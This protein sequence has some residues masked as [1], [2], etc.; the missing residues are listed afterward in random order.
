MVFFVFCQKMVSSRLKMG[1]LILLCSTDNTLLDN[2]SNL[3]LF[4]VSTL[5]KLK[6]KCSTEH[7]HKDKR[8]RYINMSAATSIR[9]MRHE[10]NFRLGF[11]HQ[12]TSVMVNG[13]F[14]RCEKQVYGRQKNG[15]KDA[16][17][18]L[19]DIDGCYVSNVKTNLRDLLPKPNRL[20]DYDYVIESGDRVFFEVTTQSGHEL[21]D[22]NPFKYIKKKIEFHRQLV[23]NE[24]FKFSVDRSKHVLIFVYNGADNV[25]VH[26]IFKDLCAQNNIRGATVYLSSDTVSQWDLTLKLDAERNRATAAEAEILELKR[27]I[28][29]QEKTTP[30]KRQKRQ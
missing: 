28:A 5:S 19:G 21:W 30:T 17:R 18:I 22:N 29:S 23:E 3:F 8:I 6:E 15:K 4:D 9:G 16:K 11:E 14:E 10:E 20:S 24:G 2:V 12:N 13:I 26:K 27:K 1:I 25:K 7:E